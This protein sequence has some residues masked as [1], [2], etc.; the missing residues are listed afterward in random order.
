M[1]SSAGLE[2][3]PEGPGRCREPSPERGPDGRL[4]GEAAGW[5]AG[6][7]GI[8]IPAA[9]GRGLRAGQARLPE[10]PRGTYWSQSPC[11]L[12]PGQRARRAQGARGSR[13]RG[14]GSGRAP[15][16]PAGR[17]CERAAEGPARGWLCRSPS[18]PPP[19]RPRGLAAAAACVCLQRGGRQGLG[20]WAPLCPPAARRAPGPRT[21]LRGRSQRPP[22]R[23]GHQPGPSYRQPARPVLTSVTAWGHG[24]PLE[25]ARDFL[26]LLLSTPAGPGAQVLPGGK[27]IA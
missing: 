20:L 8:F 15:V 23:G 3:V 22:R 21:G 18:P 4:T 16:H 2:R 25:E 9:L 27:R 19:R 26:P 17:G 1:G 12:H 6:S 10:G 5:H 7:P 14:R 13:A 24:L 11:H